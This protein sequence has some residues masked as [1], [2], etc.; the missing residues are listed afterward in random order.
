MVALAFSGDKTLIIHPFKG[1]LLALRLNLVRRLHC[2]NGHIHAFL[3]FQSVLQLLPREALQPIA[4][5]GDVVSLRYAVA[6]TTD[7]L[8]DLRMGVDDG[9]RS[10]YHIRKNDNVRLS[11][12]VNVHGRIEAARK[13]IDF[14]HLPERIAGMG[15][16]EPFQ[17]LDA[18]FATK[19][20]TAPL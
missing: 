18:L 3:V 1:L 5:I 6:E 7:C 14:G 2:G 11:V 8:N 17:F 10:P 15:K 20:L 16:V 4:G 9:V 12:E 19:Y 13:D